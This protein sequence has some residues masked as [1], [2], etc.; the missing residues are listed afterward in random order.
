MVEH[1]ASKVGLDLDSCAK[2]A[3][4]PQKSARYQTKDN[5]EHRIAY[6]CK[7]K[8]HIEGVRYA[9]LYYR[10]V[11]DTVNDQLIQLGNNELHIVDNEQSN[12]A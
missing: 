8:R 11:G 3:Y 10:T 4:T 7:H 5:Y 2:E 12:G 9:V 1:T 6:M